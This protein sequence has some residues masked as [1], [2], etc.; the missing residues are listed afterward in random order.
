[1]PKNLLD[2]SDVQLEK[3]QVHN[4]IRWISKTGMTVPGS[5]GDVSVIDEQVSEWVNRG[6]RLFN[7]HY[8]GE[9]PEGFGILYVLVR[10]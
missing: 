3:L 4:M 9:A 1:M 6:W 2:T 8:L 5:Y 10:E 7:T